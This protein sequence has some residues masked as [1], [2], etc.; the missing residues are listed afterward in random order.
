MRI[1]NRFR[2]VL[3]LLLTAVWLPSSN[4]LPA[5]TTADPV[6]VAI[7]NGWMGLFGHGD[8]YA[9]FSMT[10]KDV[11]LQ[12]AYH[13]LLRPGLGMMVTFADKVEF[14]GGANILEN[15]ARW[16]LEYWQSN[17]DRAEAVTR[18]DLSGARGDLRVTEIR[19]HRNDGKQLDICEIA[20]A[21][22]DGVFVLAVSPASSE[23]DAVVR[24]IASSFTLVHRRLTADELAG[25][26]KAVKGGTEE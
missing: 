25:V 21:S 23:T 9:E 6:Y 18:K 15:H 14:G 3:V 26:S 2:A 16:E 22:T 17:A 10:G 20:L 11:K 13:V 5:Q 19:L 7:S 12:D 24:E 8:E 4:C 1:P